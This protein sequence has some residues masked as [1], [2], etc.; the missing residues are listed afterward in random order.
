VGT[1]GML[2]RL[3]RGEHMPIFSFLLIFFR[4]FAYFDWTKKDDSHTVRGRVDL[5]NGTGSVRS[6]VR[7]SHLRRVCCCGPGWW[8]IS[9]PY[10]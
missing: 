9:I 4:S 1:F 3:L 5:R 8:R 2:S 7:P 6:S 10:T